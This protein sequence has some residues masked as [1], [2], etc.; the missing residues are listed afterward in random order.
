MNVL[1]NIDAGLAKP[2]YRQIV[3]ELKSAI[4]EGYLQP[5]EKLPSTR[6]LGKTLGISRFTVMRSYEDL[7]SAGYV[8]IAT[9]SGAF[10]HSDLHFARQKQG[11]SE[12]EREVEVKLDGFEK[13][14]ATSRFARQIIRAAQIEASTGPCYERLKVGVPDSE[15]LPVGRWKEVLYSSIRE[16]QTTSPQEYYD[17]CGRFELREAIVDYL[18]RTRRVRCGPERLLIFSGH[19]SAFDFVLR[20]LVDAGDQC[21]IESPGAPDFYRAMLAAGATVHPVAVDASGLSVDR[22]SDI[23]ADLK[24]IFVS[25]SHQEPTGITMTASRRQEL[26]AAAESR[27][28][29]VIEND[30]GHEFRYGIKAQSSLQGL[31]NHDRVVYIGSVAQVL[32]P[33]SQ[34]AYVVLP[35]HL[36]E[37]GLQLKTLLEPS[38]SPLEQIALARFMQAGHFERHIKRSTEV[39]AERRACLVHALTAGLGPKISRIVSTSGST[40]NVTF[41]QAINSQKIMEAAQNHGVPMICM[42]DYHLASHCENQFIMTFGNLAPQ[43]IVDTVSA[44]ARQINADFMV[45]MPE[46]V[47]TPA[48]HSLSQTRALSF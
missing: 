27:N 26:L 8:T 28:A 14:A 7:A 20:L 48:L 29:Y 21:A 18:R 38:Y 25:P 32:N 43:Q 40:L 10:V 6:D 30:L 36:V 39:Y 24:L 31:D 9:G 33:L 42:A 3:D 13:T 22:L 46:P 11:S 45:K 37:V 16:V 35:Q 15:L 41:H 1:I 19:Q 12:S 47:A 4:L 44:M 17:G 23:A 5:G 2:I 34:L